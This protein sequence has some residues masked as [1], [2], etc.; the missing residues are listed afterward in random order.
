[1]VERHA[2]ETSASSFVR[3]HRQTDIQK[4][5]IQPRRKEEDE[6]II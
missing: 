6:I 5:K 4:R 2:S 3:K 1:M